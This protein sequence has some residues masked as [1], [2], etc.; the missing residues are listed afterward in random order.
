MMDSMEVSWYDSE[1]FGTLSLLP[2]EVRQHIL[3]FLTISDLGHIFMLNKSCGTLKDERL[4][5]NLYQGRGG[6]LYPQHNGS[7]KSTWQTLYLH[8][9][10]WRFDPVRRSDNLYLSSDNL[11]LSRKSRDSIAN[12]AA[13]TN[14]PF[15]RHQKSIEFEILKMGPWIS[16]G[17]AQQNFPLTRRQVLGSHHECYNLGYYCDKKS[18]HLKIESL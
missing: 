1:D 8:S 16:I 12:P 7:W 15:S 6:K 17:V 10:T 11:E 9:R 5:Q 18:H 13:Q 3:L 2:R 4:F 14:K